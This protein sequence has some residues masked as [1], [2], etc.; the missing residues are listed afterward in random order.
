MMCGGLTIHCL[1]HRVVTGLWFRAFL[2][3]NG[4]M[5]GAP[6]HSR[7]ANMISALD[8][9][10]PD[11]QP[12]QLSQA[13]RIVEI[14]EIGACTLATSAGRHRPALAGEPTTTNLRHARSFRPHRLLPREICLT[15]KR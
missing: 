14:P 6:Q 12:V 10:A 9:G 3:S 13:G 5:N 8:K 15:L 7:I 11:A 2:G 4:C 1:S